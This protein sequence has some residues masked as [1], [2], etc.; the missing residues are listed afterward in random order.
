[1]DEYERLNRVS[2]GTYGVVFRAR[3]K[4][5]GRI[6]A[7]K[8]VGMRHTSLATPPGA[9]VY[10]KVSLFLQ[11]TGSVEEQGQELEGASG[12]CRGAAGCG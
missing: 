7:L 11:R 3:D 8:K 9:R 5:T 12:L 2:E 6:C 4:K 10:A 1:M